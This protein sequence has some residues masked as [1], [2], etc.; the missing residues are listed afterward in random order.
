[1][2]FLKRLGICALQS[3]PPI[4]AGLL[5]LLSEVYRARPNLLNMLTSEEHLVAHSFKKEG[6]SKDDNEEQE[7]GM[8][9]HALGN[10]EASK[11]EPA[12]AG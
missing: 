11:R 1:M 9:S 2:A 12:F 8:L 4:A 10:F 5:F 7:D 6:K 3:S